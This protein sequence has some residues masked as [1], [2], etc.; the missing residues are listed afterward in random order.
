M[1]FENFEKYTRQTTLSGGF[2]IGKLVAQ[3]PLDAL[4]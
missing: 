4:L 3:T 2:I 1:F